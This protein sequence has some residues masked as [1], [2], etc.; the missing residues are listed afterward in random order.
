MK[1]GVH[2]S[3]HAIEPAAWDAMNPTR[4]PGL[5]HGFLSALE[6][7]NS[8]GVGTGWQ[9]VYV[10]CHDDL[11]LVGGMVCYVK[12]DSYGEYV[13]DWAWAD[14]YSRHGMQYYPKVITAVPF[15]PATG[16]R[17]LIRP[18]ADARV[19]A[20]ALM[21][22]ARQE[23]AERFSSWHILFPNEASTDLIG[24]DDT[25]IERHGVQ[26]HWFNQGFTTFEDHLALFNSKRRKEARRERR[27]VVEQGI[28]FE[29]LNGH[30]L[31]FDALKTLFQC[32]Q[33]TYA[34]RGSRGYLT[35][36]FFRLAAERIPDSLCVAFAVQHGERMAMS[37]CLR[38]QTT[39]Y[40]RYWGA[41][42]N[43]DCLHFE[44]CFHQWIDYAISEGIARFDPGAQGEHKIARGFQPVKTKSFHWIAEPEFRR[45]ISDFVKR[46]RAHIQHYFE[47]CDDHTP[48]KAL[49]AELGL[50][51]N[52]SKTA[53]E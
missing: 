44:T 27:R 8:V 48:F 22:C 9:P 3:I 53:L 37:L 17:L 7:S 29:R 1:S 49:D 47:A 43:V 38:D 45:A 6:D 18:D 11:G 36:D 52:P 31:D 32:Y 19:I 50:E 4:Y 46:E 14:A 35:E 42:A 16:P 41:L 34:V 25:W 28:T 20:D 2:P 10:T 51:T 24:A 12:H 15:T 39:L 26:F 30:Q 33:M 5:L 13:F 40:G 23:L 21:T